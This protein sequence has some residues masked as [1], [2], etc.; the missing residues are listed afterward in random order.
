[1]GTGLKRAKVK[2]GILVLWFCMLMIGCIGCKEKEY[3]PEITEFAP[4]AAYETDGE[5][6][7]QEKLCYEFLTSRMMEHGG[8][9]TEFLE[10]NHE[11]ELAGGHEVLA[12]SEGLMLRYAV[13]TGD[14]ELY[15]EVREYILGVLAQENYLS[16]RADQQGTPMEVNACVDDL[17]IIRGFYEGGDKGLAI[18]FAQQLKETNFKEGLLVDFYSAKEKKSGSEMTL[19]YGDLAAMEYLAKENDEWKELQEN[20]EKVLLKGYL[21]DSFPFF[22]RRYQVEKKEYSSDEIFMVEAL[23]T[24]YHLAEV[25]KCPQATVDWLENALE[26]GAVYGTYTVD[27]EPLEEMESTAVYALCALIGRQTGNKNVAVRAL[28][29]LL[30]FQVMEEDSPVYGAFANAATLSAHSFDNLT[31]LLAL[32]TE[33]VKK[34][35]EELERTDI[36]LICS[37]EE[38]KQLEAIIK[39][40]G[41]TADAIRPSEV[42]GEILNRY[43]YVITTSQEAGERLPKKLP[44]GKKLFCI[45]TE[46]AVGMEKEL[47]YQTENHAVF[48]LKEFTQQSKKLRPLFYIAPPY[49]GNSY[50]SLEFTDGRKVPYSVVTSF[51][52]FASYVPGN[53]LSA[54]ALHLAFCDFFGIPES[55]GELYVMI[56][57]IYPFGSEDRLVAMGED[58]YENGIPFILRVM[59][60]H[61]NLSYPEFERWTSCLSYLQTIGGTVVLHDP[62]HAEKADYED[63]DLAA[64]RSYAKSSLENSG[65]AVHAMESAFLEM[66]LDFLRE[67][68]GEARNLEAFPADIML[69]LPVYQEEK[70]W[71]KSLRLLRDRWITAADYGSDDGG[72]TIEKPK[73]GKQEDFVYRETTEGTMKGFFDKSN[74]ILLVIVSVTVVIFLILLANSSRIYKKKFKS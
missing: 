48:R 41:K 18:R 66:D 44:K 68:R 74:R 60:V 6:G 70:E 32:R 51:Y 58:L 11:K 13:Q 62:V 12:E 1:M 31:A 38:Q 22:Q 65:V 2:G 8:I 10:T 35:A 24:A 46:R 53:D 43:S 26:Q 57:E 37:E 30:G 17:R 25:G 67:V 50:G 45:G 15:E 69:I 59:P 33:T 61:E 5:K 16:Y 54:M 20:T 73:D 7:E 27:G 28:G 9:F 71:K 63:S 52:G 4:Y 40:T 21:G 42:T 49:Q 29:K 56:D 19:C 47:C 14:R 64:K 23:L 55:K 36:L 39:S 3:E 72:L 34:E